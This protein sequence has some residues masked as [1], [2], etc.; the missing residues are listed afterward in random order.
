MIDS[1]MLSEL[2]KLIH[3]ELQL[4]KNNSFALVSVRPDDSLAES[5]SILLGRPL[6]PVDRIV[7][8]D[9][10]KKA[11]IKENLRGKHVYVIAT[12]DHNED[13]D[14]SLANTM[15]IVS[16]LKRTCKVPHIS[17]IAPCLWYQT[18]DKTHSQREAITVRDVADD[19]TRRGMDH[20][21]V[22]ALHSEQIEIAFDSFDHLKMEPIFASYIMN[23]FEN[24][25]EKVVLI[26]PDEGGVRLRRELLKNIKPDLVAGQASVQ[27]L[28]IRS[29]VDK[30]EAF[31]FMGDVEGKIGIILDDMV[32]SGSTMFQAANF[33]KQR[34][35]KRV[36]GLATHFYGFDK[37][38]TFEQAL[39]ESGLDEL[40]I[41][42]T[43]GE[44]YNRV[45]ASKALSTKVT[46]ISIAPYLAKAIRNYHTGGTV[47]D[48]IYK[49]SNC[50][51]LYRV[52]H[53]ARSYIG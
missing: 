15:R 21:M 35:A 19:L 17:L 40:V 30:K 41:A 46:V 25:S 23:R 44:V 22:T 39:L 4:E 27:Q 50:Q 37:D 45:K 16:A 28:R 42:N 13:P 32:R 3:E 11:V 53:D 33:A 36:I 48:M 18:Q 29:A 8:G 20:I 7:F 12:M 43:R 47:K 31:D 52:M 9:G 1:D 51:E 34:G 2:R 26:S 49:T 14:L 5:I 24:T 10:E 38:K 6:V